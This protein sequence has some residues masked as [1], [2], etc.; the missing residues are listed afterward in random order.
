MPTYAAKATD[1]AG[2]PLTNEFGSYTQA[3]NN[4]GVM[5]SNGTTISN[6]IGSVRTARP[7]VATFASTPI[8]SGITIVDYAAPANA[9]G[10]FAHDHAR[11]IG[12]LMTT[13]LAGLNSR[14]LYSP[15]ND[16]S[17]LRSINRQEVIT[18]R[19]AATAFRAGKFNFYTGKFI[20]NQTG[21]VQNPDVTVDQF[22]AASTTSL[23]A[24]STDAAASVNRTSPGKLTYLRGGLVPFRD[25]YKT[26]TN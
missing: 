19:K 5:K 17:S 13:E 11:P 6:L 7:V 14:V 25:S 16:Q 18:T 22:A 12:S 10:T 1:G 20:N 4:R 9:S 3:K 15:G 24:T 21:A 23:S 26:K 8:S 2:M